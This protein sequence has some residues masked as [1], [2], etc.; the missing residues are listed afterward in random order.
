MIK[1]Y[2]TII[3]KGHGNCMQAVIASLFD[4][5]LEVIPEFIECKD[6]WFSLLY[7]FVKEHDAE[8]HGMRHNR[9]YTTLWHPTDQCFK[10]ER[11]H[12]RSII[13]KKCLY[14]EKGINGLFFASV[15]SPKN[16]TWS[17]NTTHAVIIDKDFN[18][19]HDPNPEYE[20]I[21]KYPLSNIL[22][23]NGIIDVWI[24]NSK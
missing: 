15:L 24:I 23:Y 18:V 6:G 22:K 4:L 17:N 5:P 12:R 13:T 9:N 3:D 11:W 21:L 10:S 7:N 19:V 8:Y 16:F 1:I 14:K 2:Q 20:K